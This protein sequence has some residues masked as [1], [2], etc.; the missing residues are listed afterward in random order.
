MIRI[1]FCCLA[2][3]SAAPAQAFNCL[4]DTECYEAEGCAAS[5]FDIDVSTED[6]TLSAAFGDLTILAIKRSESLVTL[7]ATGGGAEYML[8][9]T[10][11]A[12][13]LSVQM[14][15]GPL[16]LSYLGICEGAF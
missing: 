11:E 14:N 8:S 3:I 5:N 7:F 15:Q 1:G 13:R 12:A 2:L 10:P 6:K 9:A 4:F 16:V